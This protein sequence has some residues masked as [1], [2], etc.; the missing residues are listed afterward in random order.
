MK[1]NLRIASALAAA[2][3]AAVVASP[4]D[5]RAAGHA[6]GF[7]EKGQL[8]ISADRLVPVFNYASSSV[9]RTENG[10]E[11][12]R[13][14]S[15]TGLSLLLGRS[16]AQAE[17]L[18]V[19]PVNVHT[20][21][22]VAFDVTIIPQLTLGAALA[23]G[24]GLGGT[25]ENENLQGTTRTTQSSDAPTA[26]AIGLA[27]RVGYIIPLG[28]VFAFWPRVGFGFYSVSA[29][30]EQ[31]QGNA[32]TTI[33]LTDTLFSLDLDPQFAIVPLEHFFIHVGPVLNVPISGSR[34]VST[35][36]GATTTRRSDDASVLNIG[37]SA[38]IGG[39]L[40]VF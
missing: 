11:L 4:S 27:P 16:L 39:W 24:F 25:N 23:F 21:P 17:D 3:A 20:L 18:G 34:S 14:R 8:I 2:A 37:L 38:G 13:S 26:T 22:R 1:A 33:R 9:T 15:G 5:A 6:N 31:Q 30:T 19:V 36:T 28:D 12:T 7:G 32:T 10:I 35:T 40:N 29:S